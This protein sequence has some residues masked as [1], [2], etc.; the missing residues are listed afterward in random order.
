MRKEFE[1]YIKIM[2]LQLSPLPKNAPAFN[3]LETAWLIASAASDH[4]ISTYHLEKAKKCIWAAECRV[5]SHEG[6]S[7]LSLLINCSDERITGS[8]YVKRGSRK[9]RVMHKED[10]EGVAVSAHMLISLEPRV[11]A[12][13]SLYYCFL[14]EAPGLSRSVVAGFLTFLCKVGYEGHTVDLPYEK[15]RKKYKTRPLVNVDEF[16]GDDLINAYSG[17]AVNFIEFYQT[18]ESSTVDTTSI[19][20]TFSRSFKM[21]PTRTEALKKIVTEGL[22]YFDD[23]KVE[24]MKVEVAPAK[25]GNKPDYLR[26]ERDEESVSALLTKQRKIDLVS[27]HGQCELEISDEITGKILELAIH[28]IS[29]YAS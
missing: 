9:L 21:V 26:Y 8:A 15:G 7:F 6:H 3:M 10:D 20:K 27:K 18:V 23:K 12:H 2:D 28:E 17:R 16:A 4:E 1:R 14:E 24:R 19:L 29:E 13:N 5:V 11:Q 25:K 22:S